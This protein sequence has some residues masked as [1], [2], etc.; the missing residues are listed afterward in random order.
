[1]IP[2]YHSDSLRAR[3]NRFF[4]SGPYFCAKI[5]VS[6]TVQ[7]N[8]RKQNTDDLRQREEQSMRHNR[9]RM[10]CVLLAAALLTACG[11][12]GKEAPEQPETRQETV[13]ETGETTGLSEEEKKK[14]AEELSALLGAAADGSKGTGEDPYYIQPGPN[15]DDAVRIPL[16]QKVTGRATD[17]ARWFYSFKTTS[18]PDSEYEFRGINKTPDSPYLGVLLTDEAG[19][20]IDYFYAPG[21]NG[22]AY[23]FI[24]KLSPDTVYYLQVYSNKS[25]NHIECSETAIDYAIA[26]ADL[27]E[28]KVPALWGEGEKSTEQADPV[29]GFNQDEAALIPINQKFTGTAKDGK[30]YYYAFRT[31]E[32]AE[33]EY[34]VSVV[35]KNPD[36]E[37]LGAVLRDEGGR[38]IDY[39]YA[40][41]LGS[42]T[43]I[44]GRRLSPGRIYYVQVYSN[45]SNNHIEPSP[46]SIDYALV[47]RDSSD[48]SVG[49]LWGEGETEEVSEIIQ[50]GSNQDEPARIPLNKKLSSRAVPGKIWYYSFATAENAECTYEITAINKTADSR[51]LGVVLCREDG[52]Q[53]DYRYVDASGAAASFSRKLPPDSVYYLKVYSNRSNTNY[54]LDEIPI[55]YVLS[56][57][58]DLPEAGEAPTATILEEDENPYGLRLSEGEEEVRPVGYTVQDLLDLGFE[59]AEDVQAELPGQKVSDIFTMTKD[60]IPFQVSAVNPYGAGIPLRDAIVCRFGITDTTGQISIDGDIRCGSSVMEDV[61]GM[62]RSPLVKQDDYVVY[63]T[64]NPERDYGTS[65]GEFVI[66]RD[67]QTCDVLFRFGDGGILEEVVFLAPYLLYSSLTENLDGVDLGNADP[68]AL[69]AAEE[70]RKDI[71]NRLTEAFA[72]EGINAAIDES[73]G[74]ITLDNSILFDYD[75]YRLSDDGKAYLDRFLRAYARALLDGEHADDVKAVEF[76]GHTDTDGSHEYNQKLSENRAGAVLEY[77]TGETGAG[78]SS[79]QA[80]AFRS[81][82]SAQG[83]S[84]DRPILDDNGKIDMAASRRVEI[85]FFLNVGR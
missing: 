41:G 57:N 13:E 1:M 17:A 59:T 21:G 38:Q 52:G 51:Y 40:N 36:S 78:L 73:T 6:K 35:N 49:A 39:V 29:P 25:N 72:E 32:N 69:D 48:T 64:S 74:R 11:G 30:F 15:Q 28:K 5:G 43:T 84:F 82:A 71:L 62:Y 42:A 4:V 80:D 19:K 83:F 18:N 33:H 16:N 24:R 7:E 55:D 70:A 20:Q 31:G 68:M 75:S 26:V 79:E 85:K 8:I 60:G 81:I 9:I 54:D 61:T 37:Y 2:R 12:K 3:R 45:E 56:V 46:V 44:S 77:C 14:A 66:S 22:C 53:I 63:Q 27:S 10:A 76:D 65:Y 47:V 34:T 50:P 23:S 67:V 58:A